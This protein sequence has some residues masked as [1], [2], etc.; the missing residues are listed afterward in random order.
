MI[1]LNSEKIEKIDWKKDPYE[2][3]KITQTSNVISEKIFQPKEEEIE[4]LERKIQ[5]VNVIQ[6]DD[7]LLTERLSTRKISNSFK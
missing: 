4:S 2:I 3:K 6:N 7:N 5:K 1:K